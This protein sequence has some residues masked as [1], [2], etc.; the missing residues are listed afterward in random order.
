MT[1]VISFGAYIVDALGRPVTHIP[2]GQQIALLEEIRLTVAGT[3]AAPAM[4]LAKLGVDV[5][6][7]G[8]VGDD[9]LATF[10][11]A[12][13]GQYGADVS[14]LI[15]D[16]ERQTSSTLLPIRPDGSRPALHVIGA[17]AGLTE[18]DVPWDLVGPG[19]VFH[20][21][22][23]FILP[24]LEG[25]PAGRVLAKAK[26]LGAVTTLDMVLSPRPDAAELISPALPYIDYFMPNV[27]EACWIVGS[28]DRGRIVRWL[29][30]RGVGCTVLS[31][32]GGGVSVARRG[33]A[34]TV[35][36]AYAVDVVDTTGCGDAL[37][38]GFVSGLLDGLSL[39]DAADRGVACGSLVATGL[40]SDVGIVDLAQVEEFR[41]A[42]PR[43]EAA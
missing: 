12:A 19:T 17:N 14:G 31:L 13:L 37:T 11:R 4:N 22:G 38:A 40:G 26:E 42:T 29:H 2:P 33:E 7:V 41:R 27:E 5:L 34:E 43:R 1:D 8:R 36:P 16:P 18:D 39:L 21:G 24:Q 23:A 10:L 6:A 30:D 20:F 3:A 35:V 28:E 32:G 25:A 15:T 9:T